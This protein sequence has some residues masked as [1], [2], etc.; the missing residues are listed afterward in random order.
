MNLSFSELLGDA[1]FSNDELSKYD[2]IGI[3]ELHEQM[4]ITLVKE[5]CSVL[6]VSNQSND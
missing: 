1:N 2:K 4:N 5:N 6:F 3:D